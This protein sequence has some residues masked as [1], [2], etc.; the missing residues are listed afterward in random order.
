MNYL[1]LDISKSGN[2]WSL[3]H[4]LDNYYSTGTSLEPLR[5]S[6]LLVTMESNL[7]PFPSK[8]EFYAYDSDRHIGILSEVLIIL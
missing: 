1:S 8:V 4:G 2:R 6:G 3:W 7:V 5:V